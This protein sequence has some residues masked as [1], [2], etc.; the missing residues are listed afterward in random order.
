MIAKSNQIKFLIVAAAVF[1]AGNALA[2]N[3]FSELPIGQGVNI[4]ISNKS[5][6]TVKFKMFEQ[7]DPKSTTTMSL[8]LPSKN[9]SIIRTNR[10]WVNT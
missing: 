8:E 5:S 10:P 2:S 7:N 3:D 4:F 9:I 1:F 6:E